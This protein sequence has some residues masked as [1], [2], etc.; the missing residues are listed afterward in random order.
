MLPPRYLPP[1]YPP[2]MFAML[3]GPGTFTLG[4]LL[5]PSS[6]P[7][8]YGGVVPSPKLDALG[9]GSRGAYGGPASK[10]W[11]MFISGGMYGLPFAACSYDG[12][13]ASSFSSTGRLTP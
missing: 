10:F 7:P 5:L 4:R 12:G 6:T 13:G 2:G 3:D 9:L 1:G 8:E 11:P